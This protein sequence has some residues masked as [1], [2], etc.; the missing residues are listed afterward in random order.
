MSLAEEDQ[1]EMRRMMRR[2]QYLQTKNLDHK[3]KN[4]DVTQEKQGQESEC[5]G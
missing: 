3:S 1:Y 2:L 4:G 5:L